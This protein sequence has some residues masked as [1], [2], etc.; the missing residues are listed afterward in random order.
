MQNPPVLPDDDF[1]A[2]TCEIGHSALT[3]EIE[4]TETSDSV[5]RA[6]WTP[7]GSEFRLLNFL[8]PFL[9]LAN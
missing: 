3:E 7:I 4:V 6:K 5:G 2:L 1:D 9:G 8:N